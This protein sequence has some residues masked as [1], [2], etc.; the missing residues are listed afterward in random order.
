M[1]GEADS[2]SEAGVG[3]VRE[4]V[5]E[6]GEQG[7]GSEG[8][9]GL[10]GPVV[11]SLCGPGAAEARQ[12]SSGGLLSD[13]EY[14]ELG[15]WA[16]SV[17]AGSTLL[18]VGHFTGMSTL[19]ILGGMPGCCRLVTIDNHCR[20]LNV[21]ETDPTAFMRTISASG[22]WSRKDIG[23]L[24]FWLMDYRRAMLCL[25]GPFSFAFYDAQH[26]FND[27]EDFWAL[28]YPRLADECVVCFDDADWPVMGRLHE[29]CLGAGF[30]DVAR[31]EIVRN[32]YK[33][34]DG[35][36]TLAVYRRAG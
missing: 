33:H 29:L 26:S 5:F 11:Y 15:Y 16:N 12:I 14:E 19:A 36:Y 4:A 21:R 30:A 1:G 18:E 2:A 35:T 25:S 22:R 7:S 13:L 8:R 10:M 34:N 31:H 27:C 28:L 3:V 9:E 23:G 32:E 24:D 20:D 17:E 6:D